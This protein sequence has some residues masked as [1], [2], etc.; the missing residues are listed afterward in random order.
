MTKYIL[1][2][3]SFLL[4]SF[5]SFSQVTFTVSKILLPGHYIQKVSASRSSDVWVIED[6]SSHNIYRVD[7]NMTVTNLSSFFK[8]LTKSYFTHILNNDTN[9]VLV[10]TSKDFIYHW[11]NGNISKIN[12]ANGLTDSTIDGLVG[13][14]KIKDPLPYESQILA[15]ANTYKLFSTYDTLNFTA[16]PSNSTAIKF[17]I[18]ENRKA[19]AWLGTT[20]PTAIPYYLYTAILDNKES[21]LY[22]DHSVIWDFGSNKDW[23][24]INTGTI[25]FPYKNWSTYVP[26]FILG[27]N[28]KIFAK[29]HSSTFDTTSYNVGKRVNK[30]TRHN[31]STEYAIVATDTGMYVVNFANHFITAPDIYKASF[32]ENHFKANDV[33]ISPDGCIWVATDTGL[34][35]LLESNCSYYKADFT[36]SDSSLM[37]NEGCA[38]KFSSA[39]GHCTKSWKWDFGDGTISSSIDPTH[40]YNQSGIYTIRFISG[41]GVCSDTISK[42]IPILV[43]CDSSN[44]NF[45]RLGADTS[46]CENGLIDAGNCINCKYLWSTGDKTQS[47]HIKSSGTYWVQLTNTHGCSSYDTIHVT[48]NKSVVSFTGLSNTYCKNVGAGDLIGSPTGGVFSGNGISGNSFNPQIAGV[49]SHIITYTYTEKNGCLTTSSKTTTVHPLPVVSFAGLTSS[50]CSNAPA[51]KLVGSPAGGIF[52][53]NGVSNAS[54]DPGKAG[55]GTHPITYIYTNNN[56]CSNIDTQ[57]V[58]VHGIP[59][60]SFTGVDSIYCINHGPVVLTG[61]PAGG[62]FSG[63][64]ISG[65]SFSPATAGVGTTTL[66]YRY[67][68]SN[69]C[70]DTSTKTVSVVP[71][72]VA[73]ITARDSICHGDSLT[74]TASGVGTFLWN[75]GQS[76]NKITAAPATTTS[77]IVTASNF[78]GSAKDSIRVIVKPVPFVTITNDTTI[79]LGSSIV[80]TATGG[81]NYLWTPPSSLSCETCSTPLATPV[82]T[83]TYLVVVTGTNKCSSTKRVTITVDENLELFVPDIFSPN[84]DGQN[85]V[86]YV[87]G[88]G[89]KTFYFVIYDRLGEKIF[90]TDTIEKGWDGRYKGNK[91]NNAVF[92]YYVSATLINDRKIKLKGDVTLIR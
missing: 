85:D 50:Y 68:S 87:R 55:I 24:P 36:M 71:L 58:I 14:P 42:T 29:V 34:V 4:F 2:F 39:C 65:N 21:I 1:L 8:P 37:L 40:I 38:I 51:V 7:E 43:C 12:A 31:D 80:L 79:L 23:R 27:N 92:V 33:D 77:Y 47:I 52:S 59:S 46:I 11:K 22:A 74:L 73:H 19:Y 81:A 25:F 6:T 72:P 83:T 41:N 54:F 30:I 35:Q 63:K 45:A 61:I 49:G 82:T 69:G 26:A 17:K 70:S 89:V 60:V 66:S 57:Q 56:G 18:L 20:H 75:T 48:V 76:T 16:W 10:G 90:E 32:P 88:N 13:F 64:G 44:Y 62:I 67:I 86:L 84:D 5:S 78:C 9:D 91:L 28:T 3:C 53:G 15:S